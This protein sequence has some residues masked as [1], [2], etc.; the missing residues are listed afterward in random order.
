[1]KFFTPE[2]YIRFNSP[3][4]K[5]ADRANEAWEKAG[6]RYRR[7]LEAIRDHM[8]VQVRRVA[9]L[10]LHDAEV[11]GFEQ[12]LSSSFSL[13]TSTSRPAASTAVAVLS[14]RQDATIRF[15]IYVLWDRILEHPPKAH[16]PFSRSQRLWLYDEVD[17]A[18]DDRGRFLHRILFSDGKV[19]EIPFVSVATRTVSYLIEMKAAR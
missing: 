17:L 6:Q 3:D 5:V 15:L 4:D 12:E 8:P 16:W 13:A 7:R 11:F 10:C 19:V 2:L 14:L 1:M 18:A 9:E